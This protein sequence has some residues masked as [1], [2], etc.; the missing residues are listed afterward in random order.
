LTFVAYATT[1]PVVA[2]VPTAAGRLVPIGV[3][4]LLIGCFALV[5][6]RRAELQMVGFVLV[7]NAVALIAFLATAGVPLLVELGMSVD[8]LLAVVV[9]QVLASRVLAEFGGF[10]LDGLTELHD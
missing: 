3:A 7:D 4:T 8:V 1:R 6:R 10:D 2:L 9:L 5:A